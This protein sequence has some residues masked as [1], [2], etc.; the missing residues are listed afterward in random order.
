M[1]I[2]KKMP[3]RWGQVASNLTQAQMLELKAEYAAKG[4]EVSTGSGSRLN[5]DEV[6]QGTILSYNSIAN[7]TSNQALLI[8]QLDVV[9]ND[10]TTVKDSV[11]LS[12][13][14]ETA[15]V[16]DTIFLEC[17][18]TPSGLRNREITE[19]RFNDLATELEPAE[20]PKANVAKVPRR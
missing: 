9:R 5:E 17:R 1:A 7:G 18:E 15:E 13:S 12:L 2:L 4:V 20:A 16:G 10:G 11:A 6:A 8:A 19:E 3:K 14:V